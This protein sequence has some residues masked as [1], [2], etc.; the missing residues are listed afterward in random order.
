M[1]ISIRIGTILLVTLCI[2]HSAQQD[3]KMKTSSGLIDLAKL[4]LPDGSSYTVKKLQATYVLNICAPVTNFTS[5]NI[6]ASTII[7]SKGYD[8]EYR[9]AEHH[10]RCFPMTATGTDD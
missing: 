3:C 6:C 7:G 8:L 5:S 9:R 1:F 10:T 4:A 2:I